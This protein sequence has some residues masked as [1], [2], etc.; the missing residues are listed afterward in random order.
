MLF[1][2]FIQNLTVNLIFAPIALG[3]YQ[4]GFPEKYLLNA[5]WSTI[6]IIF[7]FKNVCYKPDEYIKYCWIPC[8]LK[9]KYVPLIKTV[10]F[11]ALRYD[12][13]LAILISYMIGYLQCY[14]FKT[15]F[16]R[17]PMFVYNKI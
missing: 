9:N 5:R 16:I 2:P 3:I 11:L 13:W 6:I 15:D 4:L 17:L 8:L 10:F 7:M 14:H 1:Q 12:Q